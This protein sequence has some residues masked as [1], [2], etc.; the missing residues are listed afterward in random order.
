MPQ[1]VLSVHCLI[2]PSLEFYE[3][4]AKE[5]ELHLVCLEGM[6]IH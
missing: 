3:L 6:G 1:V 4:G 2:Y 5:F